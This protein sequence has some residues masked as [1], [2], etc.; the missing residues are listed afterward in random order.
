MHTH[1]PSRAREAIR[2]ALQPYPFTGPI[3]TPDD[4]RAEPRA[5]GGCAYVQ[6]CACGATRKVN[7][8]AGYVEYGDW[9]LDSSRPHG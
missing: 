4:P 6:A 9:T 7:A 3:R 5:H 8:S 1:R 2:A